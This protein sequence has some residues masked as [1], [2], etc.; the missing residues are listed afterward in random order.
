MSVGPHSSTEWIRLRPGFFGNIF[1]HYG[2]F[3]L[4]ILHRRFL[5]ELMAS[6][7]EDANALDNERL[8]D[9]VLFHE[10]IK[11]SSIDNLC[12]CLGVFGGIW[13]KKSWFWSVCRSKKI[14]VW[15]SLFARRKILVLE[16]LKYPVI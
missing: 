11:A 6:L 16:S 10:K 12:V 15:E 7:K 9:S 3:L 8:C 5:K 13:P 14:L 4:L 2:E 1:V